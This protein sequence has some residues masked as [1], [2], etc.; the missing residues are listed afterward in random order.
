MMLLKNESQFPV[1]ETGH[2][3]WRK[4]P[5]FPVF[6]PDYPGVRGI[7]APG[8]IQE[9]CFSTSARADNSH[10]FPFIQFPADS[11]ENRPERRRA[12]L[13]VSLAYINHFQQHGRLVI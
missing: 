1:P 13:P 7:K 9:S 3:N 11:P 4:Q 8:D 10:P 6:E 12:C 2:L 5:G